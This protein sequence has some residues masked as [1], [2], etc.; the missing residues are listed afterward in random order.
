M[1]FR[2]RLFP[3]PVRPASGTAVAIAALLLVAGCAENRIREESRK[4]M[5]G[6]QY[7]Q[8]MSTL[9]NGL[10]DYPESTS[11]RT[12]LLQARADAQMRL[13]SQALSQRAAGQYDEATATLRQALE[14]DPSNA[15]VQAL[16]SD[17]EL[18]RKGAADLAVAQKWVEA[19]QPDRA[20][21]TLEQ[22]LKDNPR[23]GGLLDLQRRLLSEQRAAQVQALNGVL[24][25]SRPI[26][27]DFRDASLRTVLDVVTRHSGINFVLDRDVRADVR[28]TVLLRQAKVEDALDLITSSNQLAKKVIDSRTIVIYPNTAEKHREYQEQLVR[29]FNLSNSDP[30][31]AAAFLKAMLKIRE[32]FVDERSNLLALRDSPE[33]IQLAERLLAV[34][35][36]AEPEVLLEVEVLEVAASRLNELGVKFP[37]SF[38]LTPLPPVG[39]DS[40]TL[41]NLD[42]LGR[43]RI[44]V[45]FNPN[46]LLV[47]LRR[48][49]GDTSTLANPKLRVRNKE[50]AKILIGDKIPIVSTT[51]GT[52]GFV[53][54]N[55]SYLDVG[56][57]LDVE[58]TVFADDEVAIKIGLEVS[59]LGTATKTS[60]G[61]IAYQ[62]GT[63]NANTLLRLRDGETQLLAGLIS[64]DERSTSSRVP[65]LGD[66]PVLG[67]LF[68]SQLDDGKRSELLLAIT[69]RVLR[70]VKRL[71]ASEAEMW[72]GTEASPKLR[73]VGGLQF[74]TPQPE[75]K[76]GA[77]GAAGSPAAPGVASPPGGGQPTALPAPVAPNLPSHQAAL[78]L[79][80]PG[81]AKVGDTVEVRLDLRDARL[82]GLMTE[83][84]F[85]ADKLT[86]VDADEDD[87]FRKGGA[88]TSF[89]KRVD[90]GRVNLSVLRN[91][92]TAAE[93]AGGVFKLRFKATAPGRAEVRVGTAQPVSLE[94][95]ADRPALPAPAVIEVK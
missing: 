66:L 82:R 49:V 92:A 69:P 72:V 44:G 15:R 29:V 25:E 37:S 73:Q 24:T 50:K 45:G 8:A 16:L 88:V 91:Q 28:V 65:G 74:N 19:R 80:A 77:A 90:A 68:S 35:D 30:K 63:R 43:D 36:S 11:L 61:S 20:L 7:Q 31:G 60:A 22:A 26:S 48:E 56:L 89:S 1:L 6:G 33:N 41:G 46:N 62:I 81:Q 57:K 93:G 67:R 95:N 55:I 10:R 76:P 17:M 42:G 70:N 58:P 54:E 32:P 83:L 12:T 40:L 34:F 86:L 5:A 84:Q 13:I 2:T 3:S 59:S 85:S 18:E 51:T 75:S 71:N 39:S 21:R 14:L 87:Y 78:S 4:A 27:L 53:S 47:N 23:H 38:S 9:E 79:A 94:P 52:G 64:R